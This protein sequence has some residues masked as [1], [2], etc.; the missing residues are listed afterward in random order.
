M[1]S[2]IGFWVRACNIYLYLY[3][4]ERER[5]RDV[6]SNVMCDMAKEGYNLALR[7]I[8]RTNPTK[9]IKWVM[10]FKKCCSCV[11]FLSRTTCIGLIKYTIEEFWCQSRQRNIIKGVARA[12]LAPGATMVF[13][14]TTIAPLVATLVCGT[15]TMLSLYVSWQGPS[16][17]CN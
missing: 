1:A 5:E 14:S 7:I 12:L 3:E 6:T 17:N 15:T 13:A 9:F 2:N 8:N 4:R 16:Y 10:S 11:K